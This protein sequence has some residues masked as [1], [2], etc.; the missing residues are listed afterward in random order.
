MTKDLRHALRMIA[1]MPVLSAV[2]I[3]SLGAGIGVNT[4]VFSWM[5]WRVFKPIPGVADAFAFELVESRTDTGGYPGLSLPEYRDLRERLRSFEDLAAF[6]MS[7]VYVGE[8]GRVERGYG[9]RVSDNYFDVLGLRPVIGRFPTPHELGPAGSPVAVLSYD[10]WQSR[11]AGD[12]AVTSRLVR[13]NGRDLPIVGVAPEGFQGTVLGLSFDLWI[14]HSLTP[15]GW[16]DLEER[17]TRGLAVTGR[18]RRGVTRAQAQADLDEAMRQLAR[19]YPRTNAT[20]GGEVMPFWQSPRGPQRFI[21]AAVAMLQLIMLFLLLAVCGNAANLVLARA[22]ARQ[23]EMGIRLAL[24]ATRRRIVALLLME[25]MV[26]AVLGAALGAAIAVWGTEALRAV[27]LVRGLPLKIQTSIDGAGLAFAAALGLISGLII[28][29]APALQLARVGALTAFRVGATAVGRHRLRNALMGVQ[30]GLA[31]LVLLAAGMFFRS[32]METRELDTGFRRDGVLLAAYDF[33][34]RGATD[35]TSG[36]FA[37]KVLDALRALPG[38]QAAAI[39]SSVP[40]DIHGLPTRFFKLEGRAR[41]DADS[42][43]ALTNTVTP[44]YFALLD[45]A[46]MAGTDFADLTGVSAP[47]QA[48]VNEAFVRRYLDGAEP[49]GRRVEVRGRSYTIVG[50]VRNS[51]SNTFGERPT[52]VIYFSYRDRRP[53]AGEIHVRLHE[54]AESAFAQTVRRAVAELDA[55]L[56]VFNV[57][58]M[59]EH[60]E[61]N[62]MFRRIPARMFVVLGPMLLLLTSIGIYAVVAYTVSLRT[63]EIGVRIALGATTRRVIAQFVGESL[64][65][66]TAG[67][68]CG[69]TLAVVVAVVAAGPGSLDVLSFSAVPIVLLVVA[70]L[71]CW[72]P[73]RRAAALDPLTA[74]R[75]E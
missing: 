5:Q 62:L 46:F 37:A 2:V 63:T 65:V 42:D 33:T 38:V 32:D 9:L 17:G 8:P 64:A 23:R 54:G 39:S 24:G 69:W 34:G 19:E 25:N 4:V 58:T 29:V 75:Q 45:I 67:V 51:I 55:E 21:T 16:R 70:A 30:A 36:A 28:G 59:N 73:A 60:I 1:R 40:L 11:F 47:P 10:F 14:P 50:V 52:P 18:L 56:P 71:A 3:L 20:L 6:G 44:G 74:L 13:V 26:L 22:S 41:A 35:E 27:P 7:P 61:S 31:L 53:R 68:L 15:A 43:Q 48:I 12:R 72:I 57:R 66:V 49:L